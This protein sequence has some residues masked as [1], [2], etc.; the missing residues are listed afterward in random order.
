MTR[1]V[2]ASVA[3]IT[4]VAAVAL[5]GCAS[6]PVA[7]PP[8]P[9]TFVPEIEASPL[10]A[11][12]PVGPDGFT[13]AERFALRVSTEDCEGYGTGSAWV[14]DE[15]TAVTNRHVIEGASD[16]I[17]TSYD[18]QR[19]TAVSSTLDA[20]AD[21]ALIEIDGTFPEFATVASAPATSVEDLFV[22]GYPEGGALTTVD[23]RLRA[24]EPDTLGEDQDPVYWL[25]AR[26]LPGNSGS[27]VTNVHGDVVGV[28]Y[29]SDEVGS[30]WAI[31][32]ESLQ[33]FLASP[34]THEP[35]E[36]CTR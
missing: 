9:D 30:S 8:L 31:S 14:L 15:D 18:G 7:P 26:T 33:E 20:T 36:A 32:L 4:G 22:A 10:P 16:I 17:L 27:A 28:I 12:V 19:Y 21:L 29:A 23:A 35:N 25:S 24:T 3:T 13:V 1:R 34:E 11:S 2:R 6:L 5:A